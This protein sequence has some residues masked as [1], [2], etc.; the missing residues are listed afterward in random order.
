MSANPTTPRVVPGLTGV[1]ETMLW[2]L[3]N[4]ATEARRPDARF[5]D[6]EAVRIAD[7]LDY[8][9][10]GHFG[11]SD[12]GH[13]VRAMTIDRL[14]R[15]WLGRHPRGWVVSLGAGLETQ[16]HR[17]D[18]GTL[19]WL[20]VDLPEAV[21][22]RR[23]FVPDTDRLRNLAC[24]A[25]D[26]RWMDE[27]PPGEP[28]F[29]TAAGLL[30]YFTPDE[31]R[32]LVAGVAERFPTGEMA[33]DVVPRW[34][35]RWTQRGWK[36]TPRYTVPV[37]PWGLNRNEVPAIRGWHPNVAELR[38]YPWTGGRGFLYGAFLPVVR[39]VPWLGNLLP[40]VVH[41]RFRPAGFTSPRG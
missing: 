9:Y 35:V 25:L 4:R 40:T 38:E 19:R 14:L 15:D 21:E 16:F 5:H 10:A 23:R 6:P 7:S 31:V 13:V 37:M 8:D 22:L 11:A 30:M 28:A 12:Y 34:F 33:F 18:N 3:Y 2:P 29:V 39:W 27:V 26:F 20:A 32:R 36:R 24:S 17:V 1:P 41:L